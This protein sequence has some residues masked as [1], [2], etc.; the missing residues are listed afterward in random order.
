MKRRPFSSIEECTNAYKVI[1]FFCQ[2]SQFLKLMA[3][4]GSTMG[5]QSLNA[6][7]LRSSI[8]NFEQ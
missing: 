5:T 2:D 6:C 4:L 3:I 1:F 7:V 8:I